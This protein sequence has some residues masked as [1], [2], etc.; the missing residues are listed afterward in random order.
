MNKVSQERALKII[1]SLIKPLGKETVSIENSY[2]RTLAE[3]IVSKNFSPPADCSSMDGYGINSYKKGST[4]GYRLVGE[5]QAGKSYYKDVKSGEAVRIF[6]GANIPRGVDKIIPQ[7][8]LLSKI[9]NNLKFLNSNDKFIRSKGTNFKPGFK[10]KKDNLLSP[11]LISLIAAMNFGKISVLKKPK[12]AILS[13]GNELSYPGNS[14]KNSKISSSNSYGLKAFI[15]SKNGEAYLKPIIKDEEEAIT[16]SIRQSLK[17]DLIITIGG[18]SVGKYDLVYDAA[19][20]AGITF[21]F[22]QVNM[23]PGKPFKAGQKGNTLFFSI[24]GNPVSSLICSQ[25]F[26]GP[27]LDKLQGNIHSLNVKEALL[28]EDMEANGSRKHF[29]RSKL[30]QKN[31]KS[32]VKPFKNQDSSN[33]TILNK[34]NSLIMREEYAPAVKKGGKVKIIELNI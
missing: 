32:Y 2:G 18:A 24:P 9:G 20:K 25:L 5:V 22:T 7:E 21:S 30:L 13:I 26:I 14:L 31:N 15:Q 16:Q 33:L 29:I 28:L 1:L 3:A 10:I 17:F 8:N 23:R 27:V 34:A 11:R 4:N 12:V 6:T 19:L